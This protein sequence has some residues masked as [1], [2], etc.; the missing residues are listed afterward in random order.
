MKDN[1]TSADPLSYTTEIHSI[2]S[3]HQFLNRH[4]HHAYPNFLNGEVPTE[5]ILG[6]SSM[7]L[8]PVLTTI[9]WH[10]QLWTMNS[11]NRSHP[12]PTHLQ[13][14]NTQFQQK[15]IYK[16]YSPHTLIC[17]TI[18]AHSISMVF[19]CQAWSRL[20]EMDLNKLKVMQMKMM[21][22]ALRLPSSCP[23]SQIL[24]G[25]AVLP[26]D[27]GRPCIK[28]LEILKFSDSISVHNCSFVYDYFNN[29]LSLLSPTHFSEKMIFTSAQLDTL[30]LANYS[31]H[32]MVCLGAI[33]TGRSSLRS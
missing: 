32:T 11:R 7:S 2:Q 15:Q 8:K 20:R 24:L 17:Q 18:S 23:N 4:H 10:S 33:R 6:L 28:K 13:L 22:R 19:N 26:I 16:F 31:H 25:F 21:K 9:T 1:L 29:N 5:A 12:I 3:F 14:F 27:G 30:H